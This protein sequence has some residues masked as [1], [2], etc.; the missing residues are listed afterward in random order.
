MF[1]GSQQVEVLEGEDLTLTI[2]R[3]GS[4]S[5]SMQVKYKTRRRNETVDG[6]VT[7]CDRILCIKW[8]I[9]KNYTNIN[10]LQC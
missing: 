8:K 1:Q 6:E 2:H 3:D 5:D 9:L 10:L 4:G 7:F